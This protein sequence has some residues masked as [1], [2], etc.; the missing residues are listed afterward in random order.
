L[1]FKYTDYSKS[2]KILKSKIILSDFESKILVTLRKDGIAVIKNFYSKEQCRE[3]INDI[4]YNIINKHSKLNVDA[5]KSDHRINGIEHLSENI[6][7]F[8]NNNFLENISRVLSNRE[9]LHKFTLGSKLKYTPNNLG[10]G[11]G[12]HR[13]SLGFQFKA[14][15]Y[16]SAVDEYSGPFEYFIGSHKRYFKLKNYFFNLLKGFSD[17]VRYSNSKVETLDNNSKI[18]CIGKSGTLILFN[19]S[20]LHRGAPIKKGSRYAITNYYNNVPWSESWNNLLI[21]KKKTSNL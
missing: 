3:I 19:S 14:M 20:G 5:Q 17:I 11:S 15:L 10:S 1:L 2:G 6:R 4:D 18:T 16:L 12:W 9:V 8:L 21:T 7:S 13:D